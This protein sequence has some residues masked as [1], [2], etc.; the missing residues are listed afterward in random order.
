VSATFVC[1]ACNEVRGRAERI[2][3]RRE[4]RDA[5]QN[6]RHVVLL[7]TICRSCDDAEVQTLRPAK[8]LNIPPDDLFGART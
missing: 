3:V 5:K 7:K 8:V 1:S 6:R 2:E 4:S